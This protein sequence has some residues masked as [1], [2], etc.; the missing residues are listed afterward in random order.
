ME[1]LAGQTG[2]LF[3]AAASTEEPTLHPLLVSVCDPSFNC[4]GN[5]FF[6]FLATNRGRKQEIKEDVG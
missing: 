1:H 4:M 2:P 5:I 6:F 3:L